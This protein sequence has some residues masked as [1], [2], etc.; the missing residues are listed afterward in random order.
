MP[1]TSWIN[2]VREFGPLIICIDTKGNDLI[3]QNKAAFNEKKK[4]VLDRI[5][6]QLGFI[7]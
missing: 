7:S 3:R 6:A 2:R 5:S 1:E 4:P